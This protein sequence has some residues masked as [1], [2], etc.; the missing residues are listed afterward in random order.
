MTDALSASGG[1]PIIGVLGRG[2]PLELIDAAGAVAHRIAGDAEADRAEAD[3]WLGRGIDPIANAVLAGLFAAR[4]APY[5]GI[6][7][8]NDSEAGLRLYYVLRELARVDPAAGVPP[9]HLV[10][11]AHLDRPT[12][13]DYTRAEFAR[14]ADILRLWTGAPLDDAAIADSIAARET[15]RTD[16]ASRRAHLSGTRFLDLRLRLDRADEPDP[17]AADVP[18]SSRNRRII[19]SG[20]GHDETGVVAS[21]EAAGFDVVGDDHPDGE[22]GLGL[23]CRTPTVDGLADRYSADGPT[24]HRSAPAER[25]AHLAALVAERAADAVIVYVRR[26]DDAPLW[27]LAA[28]R[29]RVGVPI[30]VVDDQLYGRIDLRELESALIATG[31]VSHG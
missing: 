3:R 5:A 21:I 30:A 9:L 29:A 27:D 18:R 19:L 16:L 1:A 28:Q 17:A 14:F 6:A 22:L 12:S 31:G 11:V 10:E 15:R 2:V 8:S 13:R 26:H 4:F 24:P 7:V 23:T 25:A 20:S